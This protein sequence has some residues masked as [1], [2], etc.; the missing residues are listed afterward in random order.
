MVL[1]I[2]EEADYST[3]VVIDWLLFYNEKF[4]RVN[5]EDDLIADFNGTDIIFKKDNYSFSINEIKSVWYRRGDLSLKIKEIRESQLDSFRSR[6]LG[7]IKEFIHYKLSRIRNINNYYKVDYNKL[8]VSDIAREI[9]FLTPTDL[10]YNNKLSLAADRSCFDFR[11]STKSV[12]GNS[13]FQ[14]QDFF[15]MGFTALIEEDDEIEDY[16]FPSLIQNYIHKKIELRV[17]YLNGVMWSMA[18]FSQD[19]SQTNIDFRNYNKKQPNR[20]IPF[21]LPFYIQN[22]VTAL[23]NRL[24][25]NCGSLDLILT[26]S[27]EFYFLEVNPVGQF[28]MVSNPCNYYLHKEIAKYLSFTDEKS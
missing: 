24:G 5:G 16:F 19:D 22:K 12:S 27:N 8:I 20:N 23:M 25:L 15:L 3:N 17:F 13:M 2:S 28:G 10:L 1:I 18:I 7:K 9:G 6:E 26:D 4:V 14:Y 21:N 11:M